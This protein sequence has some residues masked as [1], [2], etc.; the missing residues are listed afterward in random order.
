MALL[1]L[2]G[3]GCAT[4]IGVDQMDAQDVRREITGSV[5]SDGQLSQSTDL[6]LQ[7]L[8]LA[9]RYEEEPKE[10]IT[11]I[12]E[13]LVGA[14]DR[15]D[16]TFALSELC[17]HYA[18]E[19]GDTGYY[20]GSAILA[21]A[22]LFPEDQEDLSGPLDP[23]RRIAAD[24]YIQGLAAGLRTG[25][26]GELELTART[27][28]FP[29]G[30]VNLIVDEESLVWHPYRLTDF[31]PTVEFG[32][33]GMRNRYRTPGLGAALIAGLEPIEG[34]KIPRGYRLPPNLNVPVTALLRPGDVYAG[35]EAGEINADLQL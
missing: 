9:E 19:S 3:L 13:E 27:L 23:R 17:L 8:G 32:V 22:Y 12:R 33:R 26:D 24:L 35:I 7:R 20:L 5:L 4:P 21:Y 10:V 34:V 11:L 31:L 29:F 14:P 1:V 28:A 18:L 6:V 30:V 25:E 2:N 16:R 15:A